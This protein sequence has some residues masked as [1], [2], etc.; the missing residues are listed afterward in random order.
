MNEL[1]EMILDQ[2]V[3]CNSQFE[4]KEKVCYLEYD[5]GFTVSPKCIIS[6]NVTPGIYTIQYVREGIF[7][8]KQSIVMDDYVDFKG[9]EQLAIIKEIEDFSH[10]SD[11]FKQYGVVHKR[12]I[13]LHGAPG[14][15]KSCFINNLLTNFVKNNGLA[16]IIRDGSN[17]QTTVEGLRLLKSISPNRQIVVV[18]EEIDKY[19]SQFEHELLNFLDGQ[20]SFQNMIVLATTNLIGDLNPALLR[21]SRFDWIIEFDKLTDEQR[22]IYITNKKIDNIDIKKWVKDTNGF[23]I[24]MLKELF[25]S[26][27]L[28]ENDYQTSLKKIFDSDKYAKASTFKPKSIGFKS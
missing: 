17:L 28:L 26:V 5:D 21:P 15:G 4:G 2:S 27:V 6:D 13:L 24:A 20:N 22:E 25:I 16:F 8:Y 11:L 23:T 19:Q 1:S 10:K 7:F 9:Q 12:G 18:I 14:C 3:F